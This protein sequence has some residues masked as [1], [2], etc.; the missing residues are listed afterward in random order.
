MTDFTHDNTI[1]I[2][3]LCLLALVIVS[4]YFAFGGLG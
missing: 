2:W 4:H 3:A 1:L